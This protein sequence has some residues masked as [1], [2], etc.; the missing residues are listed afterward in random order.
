[1]SENQSVM[2]VDVSSLVPLTLVVAPPVVTFD[3]TIEHSLQQT[4]HAGTGSPFTLTINLDC[5]M[6]VPLCCE[7]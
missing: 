3:D 5:W 7:S 4:L 1:M 2:S 6:D